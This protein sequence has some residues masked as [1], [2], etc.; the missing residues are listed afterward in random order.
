MAK[1]SDTRDRMIYTNYLV[2]DIISYIHGYMKVYKEY[3]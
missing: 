3:V 2:W 1:S